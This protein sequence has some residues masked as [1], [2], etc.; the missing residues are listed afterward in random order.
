MTLLMRRR[1]R[2]IYDERLDDNVVTFDSAVV[3]FDGA[4]VTFNE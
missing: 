2:F 3:T 1:R 4:T